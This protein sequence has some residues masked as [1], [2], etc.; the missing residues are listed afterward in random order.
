MARRPTRTFLPLLA[1]TLAACGS[2]SSPA[3][4]DP[5]EPNDTL[6]QAIALT[7]G[8]AATA[9]VSTATD[10]DFYWFEVPAGGATVRLR[11]FDKGGTRCDPSGQAVDPYLEVYDGAGTLVGRDDD[12]VFSYC[13]DFTVALS[14]GKNYVKVGGWPPVPFTYTLLVTIP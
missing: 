6:A 1:I 10:V 14:A 11:T 12:S 9:V 5:G 8:T 4:V 7:I 3:P 13:E 2:A